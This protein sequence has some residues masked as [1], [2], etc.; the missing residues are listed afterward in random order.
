MAVTA[1]KRCTASFQAFWNEGRGKKTCVAA[2]HARVRTSCRLWSSPWPTSCTSALPSA[3]AS[4]GPAMTGT[5][6][7]SASHWLSLL[8]RAPPPSTCTAWMG[9]PV[10]RLICSN[11]W[12]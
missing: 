7:A 12:P 11:T 10:I 9:L 5:P 2:W 1:L 4:Y 8:L 6:S 3:V